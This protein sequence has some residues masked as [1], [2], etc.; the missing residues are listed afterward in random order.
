M[1]QIG[2]KIIYPM[3]GTCIIEAIEEKEILGG[4]I[5]CYVINIPQAK[6]TVTVPLDKA[7]KLGVRK[8]V[9]LDILEKILRGIN[10]GIT[11][12]DIFLNQRYC[13]ELNKT[14]IRT[15]DIYK[16]TE[17]IRDLMRKGQEKKLGALD[18]KMLNIARQVFVSELM[19]VKGLDQNEAVHLLDEALN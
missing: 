2:E 17:V 14:K 10:L 8:V 4:S 13:T 7:E 6:M 18:T 5:P 9:K 3:Y 16:G 12:P 19:E 11:D 1:F 15:G